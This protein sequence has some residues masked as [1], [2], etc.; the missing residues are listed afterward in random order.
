[1]LFF[2]ILLNYD[3]LKS[4]K[5]DFQRYLTTNIEIL[6]FYIKHLIKK[7]NRKNYSSQNIVHKQYQ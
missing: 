6:H 5:T 4:N 2:L 3:I 7:Q 1:M